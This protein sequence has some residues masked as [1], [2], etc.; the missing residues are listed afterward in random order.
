MNEKL[1][2][3]LSGV[4]PAPV[5]FSDFDGTISLVD[6]TDV[7]LE[8]FADSAWRRVEEEWTRG[9]IGSEQCLRQQ[10][11]LVKA[12]AEQL[13]ALIDAVPIDPDFPSF[14]R[15]T[16]KLNLP[17]YIV[18]DG[19]DY[20]IRRVMKRAGMQ[21]ELRNGERLF[22]S[23]LRFEDGKLRASFPHSGTPCAHGCATCKPVVIERVGAG[24]RPVVFIGDG[25][26]DRWAVEQADIVFAKGELLDYCR[27]KELAYNSFQTFGDIEAGLARLLGAEAGDGELALGVAAQ[28]GL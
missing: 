26:S 24:R 8:R 22:S 13:D 25:L 10:M 11:G 18:S 19:F 2:T 9:S 5:I 27:A 20:P 6:V 21:G 1:Q 17:F 15:L 14:Y 23:A 28:E 3:S 16:R 12:T 7:I 4:R